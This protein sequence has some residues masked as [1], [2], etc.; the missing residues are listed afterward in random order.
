MKEETCGC[1]EKTDG[2]R[3]KRREGRK[4]RGSEEERGREEEGER[5]REHRCW[6]Y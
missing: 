5:E 6:W 2:E 1:T 3:E 4:T